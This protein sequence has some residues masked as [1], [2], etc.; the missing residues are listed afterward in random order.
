MQECKL[1]VYGILAVLSWDAY[2]VVMIP[3]NPDLLGQLQAKV[4]EC[5]IYEIEDINARVCMIALDIMRPA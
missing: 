3:A 1:D 2:Q 5:T 4:E